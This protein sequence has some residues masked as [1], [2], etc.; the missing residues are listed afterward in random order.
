MSLC[1]LVSQL[2]TQR[3]KKHLKERK[4]FVSKTRFLGST[5]YF[6]LSFWIM[7]LKL[8]GFSATVILIGIVMLVKFCDFYVIAGTVWQ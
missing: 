7:G 5:L 4:K 8:F 2:L 3:K 1:Q 6:V